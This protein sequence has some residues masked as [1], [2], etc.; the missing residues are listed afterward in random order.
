MFAVVPPTCTAQPAGPR[1]S[2]AIG[3]SRRSSA[4]AVMGANKSRSPYIRARHVM[5]SSGGASMLQGVTMLDRLELA[6]RCPDSRTSVRSTL[7]ADAVGAAEDGVA[8]V[9]ADL[10]R[11]SRA[12]NANDASTLARAPKSMSSRISLSSFPPPPSAELEPRRPT[13]PVT[14]AISPLADGALVSAT[15]RRPLAMTVQTDLRRITLDLKSGARSTPSTTQWDVTSFISEMSKPSVLSPPP[16][17]PPC[18]GQARPGRTSPVSLV[19]S[20]VLPRSPPR[21]HTKHT[22]DIFTALASLRSGQSD[23][24]ANVSG[25]PDDTIPTVQSL[26]RWG[27]LS[28]A[29]MDEPDRPGAHDVTKRSATRRISVASIIETRALPSSLRLSQMSGSDLASGRQ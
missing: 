29:P 17:P 3:A 26:Q 18:L 28:D 27:E 9:S 13:S 25:T 23:D 24:A 12:E 8:D 2:V 21:I 16:V 4:P 14:L 5:P 1:A 15:S 22:S 19:P 6:S 10:G 11:A 20:S 7:C